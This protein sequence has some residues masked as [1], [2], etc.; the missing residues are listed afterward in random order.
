M[1][2]SIVKDQAQENTPVSILAG[3]FVDRENEGK[4]GSGLH[5]ANGLEIGAKPEVSQETGVAGV[6]LIKIRF[7]CQF[8][9]RYNLLNT[10]DS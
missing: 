9:D 5:G 2:V 10:R 1:A 6:A 8:E 3:L 7:S 4:S